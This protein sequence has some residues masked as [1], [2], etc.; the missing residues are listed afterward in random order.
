MQ[1]EQASYSKGYDFRFVELFP[2]LS[3]NS[4][5]SCGRFTTLKTRQLYDKKLLIC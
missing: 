5:D 2:Y 1:N 3:T 4:V